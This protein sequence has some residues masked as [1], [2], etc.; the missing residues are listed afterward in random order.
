M[1]RPLTRPG[2]SRRGNSCCLSPYAELEGVTERSGSKIWEWGSSAIRRKA[3]THPRS[4]RDPHVGEISP[5]DKNIG[6]AEDSRSKPDKYSG[7]KTGG[8]GGV[9]S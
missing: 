6:Y 7:P 9:W 1:H 4:T 3:L 8:T 2:A 5:S